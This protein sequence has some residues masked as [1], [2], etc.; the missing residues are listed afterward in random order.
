MFPVDPNAFSAAD[1]RL[2]AI[3]LFRSSLI[4]DLVPSE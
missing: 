1:G 2:L 4:G 3:T